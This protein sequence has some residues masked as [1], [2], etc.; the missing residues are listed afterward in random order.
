MFPHEMARAIRIQ[1]VIHRVWN[2][3]N[4]LERRATSMDS[5]KGK[6]MHEIVRESRSVYY[7]IVDKRIYIVVVAIRVVRQWTIHI[8]WP[9]IYVHK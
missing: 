8:P 2:H 3:P 5:C 6:S 7:L 4:H 1:Q 9:C